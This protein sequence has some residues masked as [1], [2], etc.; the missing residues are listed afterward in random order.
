ML[1]GGVQPLTIAVEPAGLIAQD[2]HAKGRQLCPDHLVGGHHEYPRDLR[3]AENL[4][5]RVGSHG[6]DQLTTP[7]TSENPEP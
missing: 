2:G 1:Q 6:Q 3:A 4:A 5:D 7:G